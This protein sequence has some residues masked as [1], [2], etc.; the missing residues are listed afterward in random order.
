[1]TASTAPIAGAA[2]TGQAVHSGLPQMD[3]STFPSQIFWLAVTFGLLYLVLS[4]VTLPRVA[5]TIT[6][7]RN[8]IDGDLATAEQ[9]RKDAADALTAYDTG[10]AQA[11]ARAQVMAEENRKT[12]LA[13]IERMKK[14]ADA[15][16]QESLSRA[17][18]HIAAE[19]VRASASVKA[20]AAEAAAAIVA[21]LTQ[22]SVSTA[23][24]MAAVNAV[25]SE[26]G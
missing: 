8:R 21:R 17:E 19:R 16:A 11:R 10:L 9:S 4:R 26:R 13:E 6:R 22:Q 7:R 1:V 20:S 3:V 23:D 5:A 12:I 15:K 24:A 25:E 18:K 2:S 14:E